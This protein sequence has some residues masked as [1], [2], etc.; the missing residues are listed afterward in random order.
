MENEISEIVEILECLIDEEVPLKA[1]QQLESVIS[2]LQSEVDVEKLMKIQDDLE[3]VSNFSNVD[4]FVRNE[5][6]NILS[7]IETL[8]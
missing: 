2:E 8:M 7:K 6:I 5:I 4:S 3:Y 1:R